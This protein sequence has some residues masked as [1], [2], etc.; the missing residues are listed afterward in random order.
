ML[1]LSDEELR[2]QSR[3]LRYRAMASESLAS[4]MPEAFAVVREAARRS[5]SMRHFDVQILGG[6]AL[7]RRS[8]AEMQTGEG[9]TLTATLPMYLYSLHGKGALLATVNDYLAKRDADLMRPV[10]E[11]LGLSVGVILADMSSDARREAYSCDITY[12]TAKEFGF[13]FLRDKLLKRQLKDSAGDALGALIGRG[14]SSRSERPVCRDLHF[15]LVDEADSILIDDASTPLIISSIPK[16]APQATQRY[17]YCSAII[18]K[19]VEAKHYT[20]DRR[21]QEIELTTD[22]RQLI[23]S[24]RLPQSLDDVPV[25]TLYDDIERALKVDQF[26]HRDQQY[27]VRDGEIHIVDEFTGRIAE[28][29]KW[30]SGLHQAIEAR[31]KL[32]I[33]AATDQAARIT[34]QDYFL[35]FKHLAGMSG[36]AISSARELRRIYR[37]RVAVIPTN[38]PA[39]RK[40]LPEQVFK[41]IDEKF[42]AI[43]EETRQQHLEGRPVLIGT[44]SIDKS[45]QLSTLLKAAGIEHDVLNAHQ[46]EHE[47]EIVS[48]AGQLGRV[49]VSTNMAGRGTDIKL[50]EAVKELGGLH[51]ICT[52]LHD[53]PRIDRQL[54]GRCG[55]QGDPGS[56]R[57]YLSLDDEILVHGLGVEF[58]RRWLRDDVKQVPQRLSR[59]FYRAQRRVEQHK[60]RQRQ[61]LLLYE[62]QSS[63]SRREMGLDPHLFIFAD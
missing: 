6:I 50:G 54:I 60:F 57:Q 49:T 41:S 4:L 43:V 9:K 10:Y 63:K 11:Q 2:Q 33:S 34:V 56:Y 24:L 13:D 42:A 45:E 22:G 30:R 37:V 29:R 55:R 19:F 40:C 20:V 58:S 15:I 31:E 12:G 17:L 3:A 36:T 7:G 27:V 39:I 1:A 35:Q 16:D 28:G 26:Y 61:G 21:K 14:A 18:E 51:V 47:A 44:R 46:I 5:I 32:E 52:E 62:R 38:R 48:R 25:T 8:I 53:S 23:R 59:A